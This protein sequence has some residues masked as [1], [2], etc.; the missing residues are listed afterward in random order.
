MNFKL[1]SPRGNEVEAEGKGIRE[2]KP[3]EKIHFY[4]GENMTTCSACGYTR[5]G[6][7]ILCWTD[8]EHIF[9]AHPSRCGERPKKVEDGRV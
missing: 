9:D 7:E 5:Q 6:Q 3:D 4:D 2:R 8:R 1:L